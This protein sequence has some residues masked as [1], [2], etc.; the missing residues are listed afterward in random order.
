MIQNVEACEW[1]A[2]AL[3]GLEVPHLDPTYANIRAVWFFSLSLI[4]FQLT[5]FAQIVY[6]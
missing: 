1:L 2:N 3:R 4:S 6:A 5:M